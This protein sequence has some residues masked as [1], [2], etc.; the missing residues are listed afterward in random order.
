[1]TTV[2]REVALALL[3]RLRQRDLI[4]QEAYVAA[5]NSRFF[6]SKNFTDYA[7]PTGDNQNGKEGQRYG[8]QK[9]S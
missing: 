3:K 8:Y 6:A 9:N 7:D 1:M 2:D 4:T 5:C